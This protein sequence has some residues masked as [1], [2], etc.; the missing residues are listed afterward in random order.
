MSLSFETIRKQGAQRLC[1]D[2]ADAKHAFGTDAV[3]PLLDGMLLAVSAG[4]LEQ[5]GAVEAHQRVQTMAN[6]LWRKVQETM[7]A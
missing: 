6:A 2:I 4:M 1:H 3:A 5:L 7:R